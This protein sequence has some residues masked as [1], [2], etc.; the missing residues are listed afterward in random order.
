M[1]YGKP[2]DP[3]I[4]AK[5]LEEFG[6]ANSLTAVEVRPSALSNVRRLVD[7]IFSFTNRTTDVTDKYACRV[8]VSEEFPFLAS[9]L[10]SYYDR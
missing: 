10:S 4:Y 2:R 9:K 1:K 3:A 6:R 5:A 8:D 7:V